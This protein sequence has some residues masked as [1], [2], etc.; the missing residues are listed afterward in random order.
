[1]SQG[2]AKMSVFKDPFL[3]PQSFKSESDLRPTPAILQ[4]RK[5]K[6]REIKH[7]WITVT[8]LLSGMKGDDGLAAIF[9]RPGS[10]DSCRSLSEF[11]LE[12]EEISFPYLPF[13]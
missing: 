3:S 9:R 4:I 13:K 12:L 1:M 7:A 6:S 8:H 5:L 11:N 2:T 10:L